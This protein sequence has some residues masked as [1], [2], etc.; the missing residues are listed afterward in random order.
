MA[1]SSGRDS[2][3]QRSDETDTKPGTVRWCYRLIALCSGLFIFT[4]FV[5]VAV[6]MSD[7]R[8][9]A[10]ESM[11]T[12][13][14]RRGLPIIGIEV[15]AILCLVAIAFLVDRRESWIKYQREYAEWEARM[16]KVSAENTE[17][18]IQKA[19]KSGDNDE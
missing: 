1:H 17:Q 7:P 2:T 11:K 12:F 8:V 16:Q 19:S 18:S 14:D 4:I 5:M 6:T 13:F 10:N 15:T 9:A 3:P